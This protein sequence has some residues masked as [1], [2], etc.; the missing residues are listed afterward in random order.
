M[1]IA[2]VLSGLGA[3]GAEKVVNLLA[4]HRRERGDTIHI[5]ALNT[6]QPE[7]Y[8]P[9]HHD[10]L[11]RALGGHGQADTRRIATGRRI[12]ALR[13]LL[14][15]IAPDLVISFLTKV[16]VIAGLATI[17]SGI[18]I[19][20]SERNNFVSQ[21]MNPLWRRAWPLV[22]RR[23]TSLVMQ[24]SSALQ[25]LPP[26]LRARAAVI[27]NPVVLS[28][29]PNRAAGDGTRIVA[30]GRM[31]KQK[32]FDLLI[33]AFAEIATRVPNA[34]LTIFGDGPERGALAQQAQGL[35]IGDRVHMPGVTPSPVGWITYGD[36]FVLSS[37]FE[38][39]PNV[40]LEAMTAG[41]PVIAFD[42]Q[43]GPSEI[44]NGPD[45]GLL[46]PPGDVHQLGEAIRQMATDPVLRQR[47]A[48]SGA[49]SAAARYSLPSILSQW[50]EVIAGAI[51]TRPAPSIWRASDRVPEHHSDP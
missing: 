13:R 23:A 44:L 39:F 50:D 10:I 17:G 38:G 31:E 51:R 33:E 7:S 35:G 3:G 4:H 48:Q 16:N 12:F 25:S 14:G 5:L 47:L 32:G 11:V 43:W 8:F 20:M 18:P 49:L 6:D 30:A 9:Y 2:F 24:T 29:N 42:C 36:M 41:L 1:R 40:L 26:A 28:G 21:G 37:R 27:A 19:V 46:V 22:M 15:E 45:D 34:S